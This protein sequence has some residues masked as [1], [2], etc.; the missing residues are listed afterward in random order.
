M[1]CLSRPTNM[2]MHMHMFELMYA[3][4][5]W[6]NLMVMPQ[7]MDMDMSTKSLF[8]EIEDVHGGGHKSGGLGDTI[9]MAMVKVFDT[10]MHHL[11]AGVGVSAPTGAVDIT[12]D[13]R[14]LGNEGSLLQDYGMQLGSGTWDFRPNLTYTGQLSDFSWGLQLSGIKRMEGRNSSGYALGDLF[15]TTAWAGYSPFNWL[16]ATVRGNFTAQNSIS[17]KFNHAHSLNSPVDFP[18][19]YGGRFA[20][21][22]FGLNLSAPDTDY[23]GHNLSVEWLQ[24]VSTNFNGYQLER[25]GSLAATWTYSF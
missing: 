5:D 10:P 4:T 8:P 24:P 15:Q 7:L 16:T 25:N 2:T 21:V 22:G 12:M 3:P 9:M 23:A 19:N 6:L 11:H 13:G 14:S 1:Y 17:G 18:S 20:D